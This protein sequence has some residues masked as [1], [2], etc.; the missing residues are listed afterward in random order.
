MSK[1]KS[2]FLPSLVLLTSIIAV[3]AVT[4]ADSRYQ[5][6]RIFSKGYWSVEITRDK[7]SGN[8]WCSGDTS[9]RRSQM[10]SLAAYNNG[11]LTLFV[12]DSHWNIPRRAIKFSIDI[13]YS[14]WNISGVGDGNHASI[15]MHNASNAK[16][17]V[18]ELMKGNAVAVKNSQGNR[19]AAFSLSGSYAAISTL[20]QCWN[21]I[22]DRN[23]S[24]S[25]DPFGS[26]SDPFQ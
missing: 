14:R 26:S 18:G 8:V 5:S 16:K 7:Q 25:Q 24:N 6:R 21:Y 3:P 15:T 1:R 10:L 20:M 2:F 17:F 11:Q 19:L 9:N 13:D 22:A 4:H 23:S 12:F